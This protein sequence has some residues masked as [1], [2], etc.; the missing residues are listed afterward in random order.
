[1][2]AVA[3]FVP[4]LWV[5]LTAQV[6]FSPGQRFP[7]P[8]QDQTGKASVEGS[9][10]DAITHEPIKKATVALNGPRGSLQAVTD[11]S[12][13]FAFRQLPAGQYN[14]FANS[15]KYPPV[16]G[17]ID[18]DRQLTLSVTAEE[19]KQDVHLSLI[20]GGTVRGHIVDD[21]GNP[22]H[23]I[24]TTLQ[25]RDTG[26]GRSAQRNASSQSDDKGEYRISNL[27][28]G[29]YYIEAQCNQALPLPHAFVRRTSLMD[30]PM[31]TYAPLFYPGAADP[32]G[33]AKVNVSP[34]AD[35]SGIDFRMA[36]ARG[37]TIRGHV[38]TV[39]DRNV[40]LRLSP[41]DLTRGDWQQHGVPVNQS[42]GEFQVRNVL[43][44]SYELVAF[45]FGSGPSYF[46][47][48]SVEV[49]AASLDPIDLTLAPAP[50]VSGSIS[51]EGD[52][53]VQLGSMQ[54]MMNPLDGRLMMGPPP[55]AEV[56]SDGTFTLNS[57][58]PGRWRLNINGSGFY[59]KSVKQGDQDVTP[60]D[61]EIS[62]SAAQLKVVLGTKFAQLEPTLAAPASGTEAISA[63]LWSAGGDPQF[64]QYVPINPQGSARISV[65][66]GKYLACAFG[67]A[68]S[69]V[70]MQNRALR[71]AVES[72]C[73]TVEAS[74]DGIAR[75][76]VPV[77]PADD[78]K[79]LLDKIEE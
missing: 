2:K 67:V 57:V 75:V 34:G 1:M 61:L 52:S 25:F 51:I 39:A 55:R 40:Q 48:A 43:P 16:Q 68:Q 11:A 38:G 69:W 6:Q 33:A 4:F 9:V 22:M 70:L 59:V 21:D 30:V 32:E 49:G 28:R 35:A 72:H 13:H 65:P 36:P 31:L 19:Q 47:S 79:Q 41:K 10:L 24:V 12:G 17:T 46:A 45:T 74:E 76:Q 63:F 50:S 37:I 29:K 60:W 54:V 18:P 62:S 27:P 14:L 66:P 42:T 23:C 71:K 20:P 73:E 5:S 26:T 53:K 78:L 58:M 7:V 3:L 56:Q 77:I 8:P 15:E 64:Q 44:G